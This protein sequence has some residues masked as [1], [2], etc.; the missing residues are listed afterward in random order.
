MPDGR[1]PQRNWSAYTLIPGCD[2]ICNKSIQD[3]ACPS[4]NCSL[5]LLFSLRRSTAVSLTTH[6]FS[7]PP[8]LDFC[9]GIVPT[10]MQQT[11]SLRH[12]T[13]RLDCMYLDL[14][15]LFH[16]YNNISARAVIILPIYT[17]SLMRL[18]LYRLVPTHNYGS[19]SFWGFT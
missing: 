5:Q 13:S 17:K 8:N 11:R 16:L 15:A 12:T 4:S 7:T 10:S 19:L 3:G 1:T 18:L 9:L 6:H 2:T 14:N